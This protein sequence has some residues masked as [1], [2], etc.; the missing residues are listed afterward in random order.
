MRIIPIT[1][2]ETE[3]LAHSLAQ[4]L[5]AFDEPIPDFSIRYPDKLESCIRAPFQ[6][7]DGKDVYKGLI[8]KA[9]I[10]FYLMMKNHPFQNG[11]KRVAVTTLLVFLLDNKKW[12]SVHPQDLY[13]FSV[14]VA[15]SKPETKD[16][17]VLAIK[18]FINKYIVGYKQK[19][20]KKF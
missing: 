15:E 10:L 12:I 19:I 20:D 17:V 6:T 9:S 4:K 14:W 2:Y 1:L 7:F 16:G 11:N 5:L 13:E 8:D 3:Y 18:G